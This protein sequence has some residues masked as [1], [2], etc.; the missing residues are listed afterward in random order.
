[1]SHLAQNERRDTR[2]TQSEPVLNGTN[3]SAPPQEEKSGQASTLVRRSW[4][5]PPQ[6]EKIDVAALRGE[7]C[8]Y[9]RTLLPPVLR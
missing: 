9:L 5:I 7:Q 8:E 6:E 4:L 3:F 1:M 2:V